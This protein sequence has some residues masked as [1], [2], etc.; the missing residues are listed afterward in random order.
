MNFINID[1]R[2]IINRLDNCYNFAFVFLL[3]AKNG[4]CSAYLQLVSTK[5]CAENYYIFR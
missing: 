5:S 1:D 3:Y 2:K 4:H